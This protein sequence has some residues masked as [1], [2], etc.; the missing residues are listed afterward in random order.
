M[1]AA[2]LTMST[3]AV[4]A[5]VPTPGPAQELPTQISGIKFNTGQSVVPYYEGWIRNPDGSFDLVFGYFNRNHQQELVIAPGPD[6]RVEPGGPDAGQPTYFLPRRQRWIY[7]LRVPADFGKKEVVWTLAANGR[8]ER[9]V[10]ALLPS[11][12]INERVVATNG[13]FDTGESDRNKPPT[14]DLPAAPSAE[15]AIPLTLTAT[16]QDDGLPKPRTPPAPR[17]RPT[18][19]QPAFGAQINSV[20]PVRSRG[21]T[22]NW[23]VYRGPAR[24][25]FDPAGPMPAT[26]G[27]P[28]IATARFAAPGTYTL[29]AVASDGAM[30]ARRQVTIVVNP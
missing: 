14:I 10:A 30:S 20:V 4:H 18:T 19:D 15:A 21:P 11:E 24:V 27:Q 3:L 7:R 23:I 5:Q 6:N 2:G 22:L 28:V 25:T 9:V 1:V 12:E 8:T 26:I 13:N 29:V 17:P 16:V